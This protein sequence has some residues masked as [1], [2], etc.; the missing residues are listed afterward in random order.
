MKPGGRVNFSNGY[1]RGLMGDRVM[2]LALHLESRGVISSIDSSTTVVDTWLH[3]TIGE[4][5][6]GG[7]QKIMDVSGDLVLFQKE[8][9]VAIFGMNNL[10]LRVGYVCRKFLLL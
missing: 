1:N 7:I 3:S 9:I 2:C 8:A 6:L 10:Q 4:L 5:L